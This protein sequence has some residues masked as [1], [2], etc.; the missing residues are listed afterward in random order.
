[1]RWRQVLLLWA[2]FVALLA[3]WTLVERHRRP[4]GAREA[5]VR[6]RFLELQPADVTALVVERQ[7]RR[8]VA[9]REAG[10]WRVVEPAGVRVPGDLVAAFLEALAAAEEIEQVTATTAEAAAFGFGEGAARVEVE[11]AG[12]P[13]LVVVLG[14]ENPTGTAIY[15]RQGTGSRIVLIGRNVRYYEALL[16]EALPRGEVPAGAGPIGG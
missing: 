7:G 5:P 4:A 15:A 3:H 10:A 8:L 16:L 12:R 11:R 6:A 13:P 1:M 14:G 2:V 9:R